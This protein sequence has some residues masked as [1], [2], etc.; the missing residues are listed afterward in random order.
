MFKIKKIRCN[1]FSLKKIICEI[2]NG[3]Q[4]VLLCDQEHKA[5]EKNW[6][7]VMISEILT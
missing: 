6:I 1:N 2:K 4:N 5:N 3:Y 7:K